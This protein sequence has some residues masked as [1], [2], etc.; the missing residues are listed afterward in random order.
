MLRVHASRSGTIAKASPDNMGFKEISDCGLL[1]AKS[2]IHLIVEQDGPETGPPRPH[3]C[4]I[5]RTIVRRD[6][7]PAP[8]FAIMDTTAQSSPPFQSFETYSD[9]ARGVLLSVCADRGRR[10]VTMAIPATDYRLQLQ[11]RGD[12]D[13]EIGTSVRG[14]LHV[15]ARRIDR[16]NTGGQFIDPVVGQPRVVQGRVRT[17]DAEANELVV[18]AKIPIRVQVS[19]D[20]C[21]TAFQIGDLVTFAVDPGATFSPVG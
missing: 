12:C 7:T 6:T 1:F 13:A 11:L 17:I 2:R 10:T 18:Q 19:D 14:Q 21:A 20:Q 9:V 8:E 5:L 3:D 16:C 4:S 15:Q